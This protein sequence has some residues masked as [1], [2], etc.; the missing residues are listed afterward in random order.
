[1][2][3]PNILVLMVDQLAG[4]LFRDGPASFLRAPNLKRLAER[5]VRF[6]NAYTASPL[7][8][9]STEQQRDLSTAAD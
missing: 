2:S 3:R 6:S 7:C 1:M 9:P 5:S 8:A 4:P